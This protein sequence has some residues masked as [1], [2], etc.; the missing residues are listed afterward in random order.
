MDVSVFEFVELGLH[1][2]M[3]TRCEMYLWIGF[4]IMEFVCLGS[5]LE[6][7]AGL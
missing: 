6:K 3:I 4:G 5:A 1:I 7:G 2:S